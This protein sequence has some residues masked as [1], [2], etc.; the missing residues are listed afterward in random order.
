M[1]FDSE[2]VFGLPRGNTYF[3]CVPA[4][5]TIEVVIAPYLP[6]EGAFLKKVDHGLV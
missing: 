5:A 1:G 4:R 6:W 2:H 3:V